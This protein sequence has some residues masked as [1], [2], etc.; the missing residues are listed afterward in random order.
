MVVCG[1][2]GGGGG[3]VGGVLNKMNICAILL[4]HTKCQTP[5]MSGSG[6]KVC[7]GML[8]RLYCNDM[9]A[10]PWCYGGYTGV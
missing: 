3:G 6:A 1:L 9:A 4:L 8:F 10:I 5:K 7:G 2:D